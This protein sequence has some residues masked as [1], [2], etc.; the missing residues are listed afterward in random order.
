MTHTASD[1]L[2]VYGTLLYPAVRRGV[3]G[4]ELPAQPAVLAGYARLALRDRWYPGVVPR[5]GAA[6]PGLLLRG[7]DAATWQRL[8]DYESGEYERRWTTAR[9][10]AVTHCTQ[11][12]ALRIEAYALLTQAPWDPKEFIRYHLRASGQ[13]RASVLAL[14]PDRSREFQSD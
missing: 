10:G 12:Y 1:S 7:I 3:T 13:Q 8:D 4:H 14:L 2:F 6:T 11:V 5:M 9:C